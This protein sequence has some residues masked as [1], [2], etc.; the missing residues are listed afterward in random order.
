MA[1]LALEHI[2]KSF[3]NKKLKIDNVQRE[4]LNLLAK[5]LR[6]AGSL[7]I[8]LNLKSCDIDNSISTI[9]KLLDDLTKFRYKVEE[10]IA[11]ESM[12]LMSKW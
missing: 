10:I 2:T 5:T 12:S 3:N 9:S 11:T 6:Q 1:T 7:L 8:E 4:R